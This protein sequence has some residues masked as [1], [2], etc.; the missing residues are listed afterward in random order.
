MLNRRASAMDGVVPVSEDLV[1]KSQLHR[2]MLFEL[3]VARAEA[4]L[5]G[6]IEPDWDECFRIATDRQAR[7]Y[8]A[9]IP[10]AITEWDKEV[11]ERSANNLVEML[12]RTCEEHPDCLLEIGPTVP[13]LG[14]IASGTADFAL[15]D[16]LIEVKHT[17]RNFVASDFR[18]VLMYFMLKYAAAIES[19]TNVWS[20]CLL[21]NP[22]R[23]VA[24][25]ISFDVLLAHASNNSNRVE[26]YELL[27]SMVGQELDR[28]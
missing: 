18:Q 4:F 21:L 12:R 5:A 17:D 23:N 13:G 3:A 20:S 2:A 24:L 6:N 16:I 15:G 9:N 27:R 26:I 7:H 10:N 11:A 22:R 19:D 28:R 8:D 25:F 1:E 14:W